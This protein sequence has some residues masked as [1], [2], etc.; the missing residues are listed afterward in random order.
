M[1]TARQPPGQLTALVVEDD[2][3]MRALVAHV[4]RDEGYEVSEANDAAGAI[5]LLDSVAGIVVLDLA[6]HRSSGIDVLRAVRVRGRVPVLVLTGSSGAERCVQALDMGADDYVTKPVSS[7][8]LAARVRALRRRADERFAPSRLQLGRLVVDRGARTAQI[9]D[10]I[11]D[12]TAR[13]F[14]LLAFLAA[15]P[16]TAFTH[17]HL[18][19]QVWSSS[20]QWQ[21]AATVTE[22]V[23]RLRQKLGRAGLS[24]PSGWIVTLRGIG[25]RF[26]PL[27]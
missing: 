17:E 24:D 22:H 12:L 19:Q 7:A 25:Y 9:N 26:D 4:L 23:R 27:V 11:V 14:D 16:H 1:V 3:D 13:E 20:S 8:E 15:H 6:L 5:G 2:P 18:L 10:R 21:E